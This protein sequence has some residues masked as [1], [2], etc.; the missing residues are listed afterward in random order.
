MR[1][2]LILCLA[3]LPS[4]LVALELTGPLQQ[5]GLVIGRVEA[6][7]R[8][9]LDRQPVKVSEQGVFA[10]G[11]GRDAKAAAQLTVEKTNGET[12]SQ[13][14]TIGLFYR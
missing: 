7:S 1:Y 3:Y 13:K 8:V 12:V 9:F 6:G 4:A 14:L 11:F 2:F 10:I 5:G